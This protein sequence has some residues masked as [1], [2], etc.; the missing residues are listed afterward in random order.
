MDGERGDM[1]GKEELPIL[2]LD[3][4]V[5][6]PLP[7][8]HFLIFFMPLTSSFFPHSLS[9]SASS[10]SS[11]VVSSCFPSS[12]APVLSLSS[13]R[14]HVSASGGAVSAWSV[15]VGQGCSV[16]DGYESMLECRGAPN[17]VLAWPLNKLMFYGCRALPVLPLLKGLHNISTAFDLSAVI[18]R[19]G[20]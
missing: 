9:S 4:P 17:H 12:L 6:C 7:R 15:L 2:R 11:T 13:Q 18:I 19:I 14:A 8:R 10:S 16:C 1:P 20:F 5:Y 3:A